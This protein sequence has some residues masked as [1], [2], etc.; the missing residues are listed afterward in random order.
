MSGC[1]RSPATLHPDRDPSKC[2]PMA[3]GS[4]ET[5][6]PKLL[7][8]GVNVGHTCEATFAV[9][10]R[11][12]KG[13]GGARES[14]NRAVA[15]ATLTDR[16]MYPLRTRISNAAQRDRLGASTVDGSPFLHRC[17]ANAILPG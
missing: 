3:G 16:A 1:L 8:V 12:S 10:G 6:P 4:D 14:R 7:R 17:S 5:L 13:R 2:A 11:G 9:P 15:T